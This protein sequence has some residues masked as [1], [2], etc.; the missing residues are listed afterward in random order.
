MHHKQ[1]FLVPERSAGVEVMKMII[2]V[3]D[4]V[5]DKI[6]TRMAQRFCNKARRNFYWNA[7][8]YVRITM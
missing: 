5:D 6:K 1:Q 2:M 4:E 3:N 7:W 8:D